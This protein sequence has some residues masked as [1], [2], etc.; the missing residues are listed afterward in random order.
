MFTDPQ[1]HIGARAMDLP[2][3]IRY[4]MI[5]EDTLLASDR[6]NREPKEEASHEQS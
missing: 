1:E 6:R 2:T 5:S 4:Y 3:G